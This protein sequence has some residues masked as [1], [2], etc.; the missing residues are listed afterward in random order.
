MADT[1]STQLPTPERREAVSAGEV[2]EYVKA[3][4][5]QELVT[6]LRG[7]GRWIGFG[8]GGAA[9]LGIGL[10][11]LLLGLLR[12][13]QTEWPRLA[14]GRLSWIPYLIVLVVCLVLLV[15]TLQ[16]IDRRFLNK[17]DK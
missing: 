12:L 5:R 6:P 10:M 3:Y 9:A 13:L 15:L 2:V 4:A 8:L 17:E 14:A 7:A 11:L 16:Q 1:S